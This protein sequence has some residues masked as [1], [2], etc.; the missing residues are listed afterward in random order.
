MFIVSGCP[1]SG[2]SL[3]MDLMRV[4]YG[5]D[6]IVG[7]KFPQEEHMEQML[8]QGPNES[9]ALY[10]TR[11][12]ILSR[13]KDQDKVQKELEHAKDMNP[14]GFWEMLY[15]VKG[16]RYRFHDLDNLEKY[17]NEKKKSF[18]KIVSQGLVQSDPQYI[19]KII[20]MVRHP[21]SVAKS[22]EKLVRPSP[23][24][25]LSD[26]KIDGEDIKIHTPEMFINVTGGVSNWI[27]R[28]PNVHIHYVLY[29]DLLEDPDTVLTGIQEFLGEDGNIQDAAKRIDKKLRRSLPENVDC[30]LWEDAEFVYDNFVKGQHKEVVEYLKRPDI[31]TNRANMKFPC[32]R[33]GQQAQ[34]SICDI[35]RGENPSYIKNQ[36]VQAVQKGIDWKK[37]PC[38]YECGYNPL[39]KALTVEESIKNN[40][41]FDGSEPINIPIEEVREKQ[42]EIMSK[43]ILF[44][45]EY[46]DLILDNV[47]IFKFEFPNISDED[48][49]EYL[50]KKNCG[51]CRKKVIGVMRQ[52]MDKL[53]DIFS[54]LLEEDVVLNFPGK[55][56]DPI[57]EEFDNIADMQNFLKDLKSKGKQIQSATPSPNGKGGYLLVVM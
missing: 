33:S 42:G 16:V 18:C 15:T 10:A 3:M 47:E 53:N 23:I 52:D 13:R 50:S 54:K 32:F 26:I 11:M 30:D 6:R 48:W 14:N 41:W 36:R 27:L 49:K 21:R 51:S 44:S 8:Q 17:K 25:N 5:E 57:V 29:D 9:D 20:F 24:G 1:R 22:Q 28:Y 37:E 19:D 31:A 56:E 38:I 40:F 2:T 35:C 55:I 34:H 4:A 12:Y 7:K 39:S 43:D 45:K 46:L